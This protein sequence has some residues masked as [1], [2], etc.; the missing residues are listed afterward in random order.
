MV[1]K[2]RIEMV[3]PLTFNVPLEVPKGFRNVIIGCIF[4][5]FVAVESVVDNTWC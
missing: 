5:K 4:D 2:R 1:D 3:F